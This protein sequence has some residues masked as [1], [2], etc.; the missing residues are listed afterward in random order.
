MLSSAPSLV[1]LPVEPEIETP[2]EA[3]SPTLV[4]GTSPSNIHVAQSP[5][6]DV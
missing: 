2:A 5:D 1:H 4:A 6:S 3:S